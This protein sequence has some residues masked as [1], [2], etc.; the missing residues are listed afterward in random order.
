[1]LAFL[2]HTAQIILG[3]IGLSALVFVHELGHFLMAKYFKV[4]VRAFSIGFGKK[5]LVWK[6]GETQYCISAI[7]FGGYVAMA[8]ENRDE[9][10]EQPP[11]PG[12]FTA[13]P[14]RARA[15]IAFAGPA[16]NIIFALL[17]L[18]ILYMVGVN[19]PVT[20]RL[21]VGWVAPLSPG[22]SAGVKAGDTIIEVN[23]KPAQGWNKFHEEIAT[24]IGYPVHITVLT[25]E[26]LRTERVIVPNERKDLGVGQDGILPHLAI[27]VAETPK[28][29]SPAHLAGLQVGDV[30]LKIDG[31]RIDS[32][33]DVVHA[34]NR[35]G[36]NQVEFSILRNLDTLKFKLTPRQDDSLKRRIVGV[37]LGMAELV[38]THVVRRGFVDAMKKSVVTSWQLSTSIFRYLKRMA[39]GRIK[40]KAMSSA[41][42][43]VAIIGLAWLESFRDLMMILALI[44]V[45][46]GVMNLLPLAITD[47]GILMFLGLEGIRGKPVSRKVQAMIQKVAMV[48]FLT[49]FL[50]LSF[51]DLMRFGMFLK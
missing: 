13:K 27:V 25:K 7:P 40:P 39:E 15:A 47:G 22:A 38:E 18:Q 14:I 3:L 16:V 12:D 29:Q 2:G 44:S 21:T 4:R 26:G 28:P 20:D 42:G 49:L 8:G 32:A 48:L 11:Q 50:Y 46:L 45:N 9:D 1:M 37:Q 5:L 30:I 33:A 23:G 24:S 31:Q 10:S 6:H 43:I 35:E 19:E 41:P 36:V 17:I 34:L 51:Q